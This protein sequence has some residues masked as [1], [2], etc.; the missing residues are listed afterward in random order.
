MQL[1]NIEG[2]IA[3]VFGNEAVDVAEA[4][5]GQ[6]EASPQR[7]FDR[8]DEFGDWASGVKPAEHHTRSMRGDLGAP[9][10]EPRQVFAVALNYSAHAEESGFERPNAPLIFTKF[11]T[12]I[13]GPRTSVVLPTDTVD[14]EVELVV[15][16]GRS[17]KDIELADAW[18]YVAGLC[19]GQDL[20][21]RTSQHAGPAPQFSL[22]KSF[23]GFSPLGGVLF[24]PDELGDP[25][26]LEITCS[27]DGEQVQAGRT[28]QMLFS[29]SEQIAYLSTIVTL[30]PG[31]LI[32]T[33]TP[34]GVGAGRV[35]P[36]YLKP[37]EKLISRI[38][39]LGELEQTFVEKGN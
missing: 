10:P 17:A 21:E 27:I 31:D 19:V 2:R 7:I 3:L 9:V 23:P 28:S 36:R 13:T 15:V 14:W 12:S 37:G 30:Q 35:P 33:G 20:S 39:G 25:D 26:D 6:F 24:T 32:F 18:S 11:P 1:A 34:A 16:I 29:V 5:K 8:W 22:A 38:E 4:S